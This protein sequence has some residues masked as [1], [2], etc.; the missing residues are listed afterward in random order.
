MER[1]ATRWTARASLAL[2]TV[3]LATAVWTGCRDERTEVSE[4][5]R[6]G[7]MK[8]E[9]LTRVTRSDTPKGTQVEPAGTSNPDPDAIE[10]SPAPKEPESAEQADHGLSIRRLV[11]AGQIEEREP[12]T[13]DALR[14][15]GD[16]IYAFLEL[17]NDSDE[18]KQVV[19]TFEH[20]AGPR[21]GHVK[22]DVPANQH[23]WRTWAQTGLVKKP[24]K[25]TAVVR[26]PEGAELGRSAFVAEG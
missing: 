16:P 13:T 18:P 1:N 5:G 15:N 21:V 4:E 10:P 2:S 23:R 9:P 19:V 6:V 11:V 3:A 20:P 8:V 7:T 22:L 17:R 24:G 25:W 26:S 14:A 12:V